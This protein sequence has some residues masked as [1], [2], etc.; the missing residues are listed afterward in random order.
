[1]NVRM[2]LASLSLIFLLSACSSINKPNKIF[3][4]F[5]QQDDFNIALI[6]LHNIAILGIIDDT[7]TL[8]P[9][10]KQKLTEQ[11][12]NAFAD[13]VD[14]ENL[15]DTRTLA[16]Q[17]GVSKYQQLQHAAKKNQLELM[18]QLMT[19]STDT[20]RYLLTVR[21]TENTD[22][23]STNFFDD[24]TRYGRLVGLTMIILDTQTNQLV[25][26]GHASRNNKNTY[27]D[28]DSWNTHDNRDNNRNNDHN[29]KAT[30]LLALIFVGLI[31]S[32]I[33][34]E[35]QSAKDSLNKNDLTTAFAQVVNDFT[36][37]LP[38]FYN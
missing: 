6:S 23:A 13:R 22:H 21:L 1:M 35:R 8:K 26:D 34:D 18:S 4:Y 30:E 3:S 27:C 15:I 2:T 33:I 38:S 25:W 19:S 17:I 7:L 29:N 28:D 31:V 37:R 12:F 32:S 5:H 9:N 24:C 11:I 36:N 20:S 14:A 10:E 16:E